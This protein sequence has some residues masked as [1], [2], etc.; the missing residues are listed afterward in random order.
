MDPLQAKHILY[1]RASLP[2]VIY[3]CTRR[4]WN[5]A[6]DDR[7]NLNLM[8]PLNEM[9]ICGA[10]WLTFRGG[11]QRFVK[12]R[13]V[14]F[15]Y[16]LFLLKH[17][18][19]AKALRYTSTVPPALLVRFVIFTDLKV[20]CAFA[21]LVF[22]MFQRK[23]EFVR[24]QLYSIWFRE[25]S[26]PLIFDFVKVAGHCLPRVLWGSSLLHF[27]G[28]HICKL[29][30]HPRLQRCEIQVTRNNRMTHLIAIALVTQSFCSIGTSC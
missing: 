5:M 28:V 25:T 30:N 26:W 20:Y 3:E 1:E 19:I 29:T 18:Q 2:G 15:Q 27:N 7:C 23:M 24:V 9:H 12:R 10:H 17:P 6:V 4:P 21:F 14:I 11:D 13:L 22:D 8:K 16:P